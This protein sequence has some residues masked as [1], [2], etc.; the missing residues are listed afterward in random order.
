MNM[1]SF[2][3]LTRDDQGRLNPDDLAHVYY[4]LT[5]EQVEVLAHSDYIMY[6]ELMSQLEHDCYDAQDI[7]VL[8]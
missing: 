1:N 4:K 5:D 3:A 8:I 7:C 6:Y 2:N